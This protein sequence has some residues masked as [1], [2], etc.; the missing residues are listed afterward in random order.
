MLKIQGESKSVKSL[1]SLSPTNE[2]YQSS[3]FSKKLDHFVEELI[4]KHKIQCFQ[5]LWA[6]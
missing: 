6:Y 2:F 1:W 4:T 5:E 3:N